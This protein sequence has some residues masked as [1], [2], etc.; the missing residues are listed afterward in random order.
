ILLSLMFFATVLSAKADQLAYITK[1]QADKT[2]SYLKNLDY[3]I[4]FCG[5]CSESYEEYLN[6]IDVYSK[7]TGYEDYY[8]VI[9]LVDNYD[10]TTKEH[11]ID[12]A[13]IH[14]LK[15]DGLAYCLGLE[16]GF[17]CDPCTEPF[18]VYDEGYE[19]EF[20]F[21]SKSEAEAVKDILK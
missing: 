6:Y 4:E 9:L 19:E 8:E 10:G 16:L 21:I 15:D 7:H 11:P 18:A 14:I 20:F 3:V 1:S 13:Y 12:L 17:E 5:C 2:V